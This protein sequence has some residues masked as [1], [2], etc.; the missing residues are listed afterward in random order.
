M[1]KRRILW[2]FNLPDQKAPKFFALPSFP[3]H[4]KPIPGL[5][6]FFHDHLTYDT[7]KSLVSLLASSLLATAIQAHR[8]SEI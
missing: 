8:T 5:F 1:N 6:P 7:M 4:H 2:V 3:V